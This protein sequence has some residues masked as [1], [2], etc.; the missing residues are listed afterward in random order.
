MAQASSPLTMNGLTQDQL[1]DM[2]IQ[3]PK[4]S[5]SQKASGFVKK[6]LDPFSLFD[7]APDPTSLASK[8]GPDYVALEVSVISPYGVGLV[9]GATVTRDGHLYVSGGITMGTP[10]PGAAARDGFIGASGD[11]TKLH[12][13]GDI[14]SFVSSWSIGASGTAPGFSAGETL[15]QVDAPLDAN[16]WATEYGFGLG[17]GVGVGL[18]YSWRMG[19]NVP[20][21]W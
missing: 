11:R 21:T 7:A 5:L 17:A 16:S 18:T 15:G 1:R 10:G 2:G 20:D 6:L 9:G 14:D 8:T 13:P 3:L 12:D 19:F 4:Q